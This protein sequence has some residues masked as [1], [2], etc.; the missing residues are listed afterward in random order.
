MSPE[1]KNLISSISRL[2]GLGPRSGRRASLYLLQNPQTMAKL[3]ENMQKTLDLAVNCEICGN[4]DVC[5][6]CSLCIDPKRDSSFLC[7]VGNI[8]DL[9][10]IERSSCFQGRYLVLGHYINAGNQSLN[11]DRLHK[12]LQQANVKEILLALGATIDGQTTSYYLR[13]YI[14]QY[15]DDIKISITSQGIPMGGELDYLDSGTVTTAIKSR[16]GL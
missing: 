9:W 3:I 5:D 6:P 10:A 4:I 2:P 15:R 14:R 1:I 11:L 12:F 8:N 7:I 13:D 16:R